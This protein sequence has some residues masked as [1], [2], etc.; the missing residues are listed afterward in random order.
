MGKIKMEIV[1]VMRRSDC[2]I[3]DLARFCLRASL[4]IPDT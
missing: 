1:V 4:E 2:M 3:S